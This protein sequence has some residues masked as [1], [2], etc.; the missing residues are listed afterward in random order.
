MMQDTFIVIASLV[1]V[2]IL[3]SALCDYMEQKIK[4]KEN[5]KNS[6]KKR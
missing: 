1:V 2:L 4:E 5:T 3:F 6:F